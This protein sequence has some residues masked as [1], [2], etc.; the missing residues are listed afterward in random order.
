LPMR[1]TA[2]QKRAVI[3]DVRSGVVAP[4]LVL[5]AWD[6]TPE[7]YQEWV[8]SFDAHGKEALKVTKLQFFR[9][10]PRRPQRLRRR[11]VRV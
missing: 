10:M 6:I 9:G 1:W 4:E 5:A 8:D 11:R 7:E 3:E 2:K